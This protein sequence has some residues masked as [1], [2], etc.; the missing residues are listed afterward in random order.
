MKFMPRKIEVSHRTIVFTIFFL[1]LLWILYFIRDIILEFFLALLI[2]AVLDPFVTKLE[3]YKIPRSA[4]VIIAYLILFLLIGFSVA[5]IIP[6][7]AEQTTSF[8]NNLPRFLGS[9]GISSKVSEQ[10]IQQ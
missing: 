1:I 6:Q 7:L 4:S 8:V 10:V 3:E 5:G 2:M 9:L